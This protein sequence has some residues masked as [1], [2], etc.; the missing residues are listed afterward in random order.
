VSE[1]VDQ[2]EL[3]HIHKLDDKIDRIKLH[4]FINE[5]R[6]KY[7]EN[8]PKGFMRF[9]G[10]ENTKDNESGFFGG[11][12]QHWMLDWP[13]P[14]PI[15]VKK[16]KGVKITDLDDNELIDLCLGDTGAM[17]GHSPDAIK[18]ALIEAGESGLTSMLPSQ[19]SQFVGE[20]LT[21]VFGLPYWQLA[22]SASDAN[23]FALRV[24]RLA[25]GRQKILVFDGCYHG[26][27]DE[28][29]VCL[30][31]NGKTI[32]KPS[33]WGSAFDP[34]INTYCVPFNDEIELEAALCG[35]DIAC[36][37]MEPALTNCGIVPPKD[38]FLEFV[39][40]VA[41]KHGTLVLMD[42]THTLSTGLGGYS[43]TYNLASDLFV[44]GKAVAGG[45]PCAIWGFSKEV[46]DAIDNA[47]IALPSGH[48]GI[49]TTLGG[50]LLQLKALKASFEQIMTDET[51]GK[52]IDNAAKLENALNKI[53]QTM[54]L[55]WSIIRIGARLE[56]IFSKQIPKNADEMRAIFDYELEEAIH[57]GLI[58]R[59]FLVTPFHNMLLAAPSLSD[60]NILHYSHAVQEILLDFIKIKGD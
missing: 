26:A 4:N 31:K 17:F 18:N 14:F 27:V 32:A 12:P 54:Q 40:R 50:S 13:T 46:K 23:R 51:Y 56:I 16:A 39:L 42:E 44:A 55:N 29:T 22:L 47:R 28:T 57:L 38:G 37:I 6:A 35:Q 2:I 48:S 41:K 43:K 11:V 53:I 58:N 15:Y 19:Y 1:F 20:K 52:M 45:I 24:A 3:E 9:N 36:I 5:A 34:A 25:T 8:R 30:D 59:G 33:L 10:L 21:E 7:I 60:E 49:G